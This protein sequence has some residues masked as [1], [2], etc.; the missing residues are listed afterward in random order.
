MLSFY[1]I[2]LYGIASEADM[3]LN[4][5]YISII[6]VVVRSYVSPVILLA[7]YTCVTHSQGNTSHIVS[8]VSRSAPT[9]PVTIIC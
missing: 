7:A 9:K 4:P 6:I 1:F 8:C 5:M 3:Y 2:F